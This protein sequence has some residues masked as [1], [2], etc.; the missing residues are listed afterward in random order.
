[1]QPRSKPLSTQIDRITRLRHA[2]KTRMHIPY[3]CICIPYRY[4]VRIYGIWYTCTYI[5]RNPH[6]YMHMHMHVLYMRNA[7]HSMRIDISMDARIRV[8]IALQKKIQR[9]TRVLLCQTCTH[10]CARAFEDR[11]STNDTYTH[12]ASGLK[13]LRTHKEEADGRRRKRLCCVHGKFLF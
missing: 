13:R 5:V 10:W 1:M 7:M 2:A 11:K 6:T 9:Y 12:T 8:W 3:I 4:I